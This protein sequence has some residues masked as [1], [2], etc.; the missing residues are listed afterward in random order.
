MR[1]GKLGIVAPA[2]GYVLQDF[3]CEAGERPRPDRHPQQTQ[4]GKA[5]PCRHAPHLPILA[6][7]Q[8]DFQPARRYCLAKAHRR[9]AWPQPV[10]LRNAACCAWLRTKVTQVQPRAQEHERNFVDLPVHL[11]QIALGQLVA[12][13]GD[14]VLQGSVAREQH[15]PLAIRIQASG[16]IDAGHRNVVLQGP[17]AGLVGE[18]AQHAEG[19]VEEQQARIRQPSSP[20]VGIFYT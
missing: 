3:G 5:D 1:P 10:G 20:D 2:S 13:I 17:A 4:G 6:L 12:R 15:Q 16:R 19:L 8:H 11:H 14:A 7:A 18:L 9:V